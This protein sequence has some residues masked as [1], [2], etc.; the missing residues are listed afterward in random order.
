MNALSF[1]F[2][3]RVLDKKKITISLIRE[4]QITTIGAKIKW[5]GENTLIYN[6][7]PEVENNTF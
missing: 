3:L 6:E 1:P 5:I 4:P 2:N 7:A